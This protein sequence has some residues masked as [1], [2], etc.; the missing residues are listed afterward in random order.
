MILY[1]EV[2]ERAVIQ[3]NTSIL[4]SVVASCLPSSTVSCRRRRMHAWQ[5]ARQL[6]LRRLCMCV[7]SLHGAPFLSFHEQTTV[8]VCKTLV[9]LGW[10]GRQIPRRNA[11]KLVELA[12]TAL[13][14]TNSV[15]VD[16][17]EYC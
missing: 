15:Q 13:N 9:G 7:H 5:P 14:V 17:A 12:N 2:S 4:R 1:E 8:N 10:A 11:N 6:L 16:Q 3:N